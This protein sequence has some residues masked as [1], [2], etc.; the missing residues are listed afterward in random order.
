M[1]SQ[2]YSQMYLHTHEYVLTSVTAAITAATVNMCCC[3]IPAGNN[4]RMAQTSDKRFSDVVGVDEA[5]AEVQEIVSYLKVYCF[6][7]YS[8]SEHI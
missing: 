8:Y 3:S 1:Y 7:L 6:L 2:V 4:A 5:K